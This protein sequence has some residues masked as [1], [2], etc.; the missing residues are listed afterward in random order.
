MAWQRF[1][2]NVKVR[3]Q[4]NAGGAATIGGALGV[5]GLSTM[6]GGGSVPAGA[7]LGLAGTTDLRAG[8]VLVPGGVGTAGV[9]TA[10]SQMLVMSFGGGSARLTGNIGG[11]IYTWLGIAQP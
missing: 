10:N 9:G 7:N 1:G 4:I 3:G 2:G 11:T 8:T 6:T 5:T